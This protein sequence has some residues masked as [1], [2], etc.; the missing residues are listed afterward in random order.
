MAELVIK[1]IGRSTAEEFWHKAPHA[2]VFIKPAVLENLAVS[3]DW[4]GCFS[5]ENLIATWPICI[6]QLNRVYTPEFSYYVGPL[7]STEQVNQPEHRKSS[8]LIKIFSS[9]ARFFEMNYKEF[10]FCLDSSFIDIRFFLW[11][12]HNLTSNVKYQIIPRYTAQINN[13]QVLNEH[14]IQS[15]FRSV[16][17]QNIK[18][19]NQHG[20]IH[21]INHS[22]KCINE[23]TSMYRSTLNRQGVNTNEHTIEQIEKLITN[24]PNEYTSFVEIYSNKKK[25]AFFSLL[26]HSQKT[27]N[28]V[29]NMTD[30]EYRNTGLPSLGIYNTIIAAKKL[31]CDQFDFNGANSP[32][33][34]DDKHSYGAEPV[35]YFHIKRF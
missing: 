5:N 11:E 30:N 7:L 14:D 16:R 34:A 20:F 4:W 1:K 31:G 28:L 21:E 2:S 26:L 13:L 33:R 27:A 23:A 8:A 22:T 15:K 6:N 3:I 19:A 18:Y 35:L 32:N 24:T 29:L 12:N 10:E 9:F 25:L 17:R